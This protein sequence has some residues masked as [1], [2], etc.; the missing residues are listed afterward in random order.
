VPLSFCSNTVSDKD[1]R[2][3]ANAI[4]KFQ[5]QDLPDCQEMP[6]AEIFA[7]NLLD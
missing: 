3:M 6:I 7:T 5:N 1:K 2:E 4:L